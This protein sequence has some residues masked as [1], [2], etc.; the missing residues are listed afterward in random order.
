MSDQR[1][2]QCGCVTCICPDEW[3][4]C[5]G[6]GARNC[7]QPGRPDEHVPGGKPRS[8]RDLIESEDALAKKV[9]ALKATLE[10]AIRYSRPPNDHA[11][12]SCVPDSGVLVPGFLCWWHRSAILTAS[13][14]EEPNNG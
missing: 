7:G 10:T 13:P 4:R 12:A 14:R 3:E 8:I 2:Y 6:C 11:C 9:E 5:G 1:V